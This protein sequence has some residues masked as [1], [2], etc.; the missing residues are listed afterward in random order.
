[1]A[2]STVA[3]GAH[4]VLQSASHAEYS[5]SSGPYHPIGPWKDKPRARRCF[6]T[7]TVLID[8]LSAMSLARTGMPA[9]LILATS[10]ATLRRLALSLAPSFFRAIYPATFA[11]QLGQ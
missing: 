4:Q 3:L 5:P 9:L 8:R 10:S 7:V 6:P 1:M 11:P 2:P